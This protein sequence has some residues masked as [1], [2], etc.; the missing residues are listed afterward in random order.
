[1]IKVIAF[2]GSSNVGKTTLIKAYAKK[3]QNEGNLVFI[4]KPTGDES[5]YGKEYDIFSFEGVDK[6]Y[7]T[8][9][10]ARYQKAR[11]HT[12]HGIDLVLGKKTNTGIVIEN[13][14]SEYIREANVQLICEGKIEQLHVVRML[15]NN[16]KTNKDIYLLVDRTIISSLIYG[17]S[18]NNVSNLETLVVNR[19]HRHVKCLKNMVDVFVNVTRE[20][21]FNLPKEKLNGEEYDK[22]FDKE[23]MASHEKYQKH[24]SSF[25]WLVIGKPKFVIIDV[26]NEEPET[27]ASELHGM[28]SKVDV[29]GMGWYEFMQLANRTNATYNADISKALFHDMVGILGE[30]N[31]VFDVETKRAIF[32]KK[33]LTDEQVQC[34]L[35][36]VGDTLWYCG[37]ALYDL[38]RVITE[39]II[40]SEDNIAERLG[41][42]ICGSKIVSYIT[43]CKLNT[44]YSLH[45]DKDV[46][47]DD[48][49]MGIFQSELS[50]IASVIDDYKKH[51]FYGQP[52]TSVLLSNF[53]NT[54]ERILTVL[55]SLAFYHDM[56]METVADKVF[57]KLKAR[58]PEKFSVEDSINR[59]YSKESEASGLL[60]K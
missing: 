6:D 16:I 58:Y 32:E 59:D 41:I 30:L 48:F 45:I 2:E 53:L 8:P 57:K 1:M 37:I 19:E 54:V 29:S 21:P 42:N 33:P 60:G 7:L 10:Q 44:T 15:L 39:K 28:V 35:S 55:T 43:S 23:S 20:T 36:E 26:A 49:F 38:D 11:E 56:D 31:E 40:S 46:N 51:Y 22:T 34:M 50:R 17:Y 18:Y 27:L 25:F 14:T 4:H 5:T 24:Y 12:A 9:Y 13:A 47:Q 52:L 3:L